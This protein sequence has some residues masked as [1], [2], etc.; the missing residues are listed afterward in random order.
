MNAGVKGY[1]EEGSIIRFIILY[2]DSANHV[3]YAT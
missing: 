3:E 2:G 1:E